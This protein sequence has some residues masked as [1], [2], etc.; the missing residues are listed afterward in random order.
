[1]YNWWILCSQKRTR[2][3]RAIVQRLEHRMDLNQGHAIRSCL[4]CAIWTTERLPWLLDLTVYR[5]TVIAQTSSRKSTFQLVTVRYLSLLNNSQCCTREESQAFAESSFPNH[6]QQINEPRDPP[7]NRADRSMD[8]SRRLDRT[9][10]STPF[11]RPRMAPRQTQSICYWSFYILLIKHR[12]LNSSESKRASHL[13]ILT[14]NPIIQYNPWKG[15]AVLDGVW[16][17]S[18]S[19]KVPAIHLL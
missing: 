18:S 13:L 12:T 19:S 1:M 2:S 15:C 9:L 5:K 6:E 4:R 8:P 7:Y 11:F 16:Y 17:L 14:E 10:Y 3:K